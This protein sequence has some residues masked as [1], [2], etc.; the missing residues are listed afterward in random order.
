M[1]RVVGCTGSNSPGHE[2]PVKD[3][4]EME[5]ELAK[6]TLEKTELQNKYTD[7]VENKMATLQRQLTK[8]CEAFELER[9]THLGCF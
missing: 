2:L 1:F 4:N 3:K 8:K 6:R 7:V 5:K 9:Q